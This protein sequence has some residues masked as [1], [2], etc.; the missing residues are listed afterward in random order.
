MSSLLT[1]EILCAL[2]PRAGNNLI[3]TAGNTYRSDDG[4]GPFVAS[5]LIN[6]VSADVIDAKDTPENIVDEA[7]ALKPDYILVIDAADF[8][9]QAGEV[10]IISEELIPQTTLSTHMI[11]L[12]VVIKLI[13]SETKAEVCFIGVQPKNVG[14]GEGLSGEVENTAEAL[15]QCLIQNF[16]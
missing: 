5:S 7:I 13:T 6:R 1:A 16:K 11:P 15:I 8:G 4:M 9:G 12:S 10:R 2:T 14:F 3:L